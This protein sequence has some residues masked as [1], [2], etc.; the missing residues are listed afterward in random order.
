MIK[1]FIAFT[2]SLFFLSALF[3]VQEYLDSFSGETFYSLYLCV[4]LLVGYFSSAR[5]SII[6]SA[7]FILKAIFWDFQ[8]VKYETFQLTEL[9]RFILFIAGSWLAMLIIRKLRLKSGETETI[10]NQ[11]GNNG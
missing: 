3:V 6:V 11:K 8:F 1:N 4:I 2:F 7:F 5:Y 10:I 9:V